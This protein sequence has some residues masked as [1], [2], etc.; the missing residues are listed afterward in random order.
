MVSRNGD[1]LLWMNESKKKEFRMKVKLTA[2]EWSEACF[3][4]YFNGRFDSSCV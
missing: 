3:C 1:E 4:V 2:N